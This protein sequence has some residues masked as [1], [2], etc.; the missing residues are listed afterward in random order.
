MA[1]TKKK[2]LKKTTIAKVS[3]SQ[4]NTSTNHLNP[5]FSFAK[6]KDKTNYSVNCMDAEH[7]A[8]LSKTLFKLGQSTWTIIQGSGRHGF[9]YE[10]IALNSIK[11]RQIRN[12]FPD[13]ETP[14]AFRFKGKAPM[15]GYRDDEIFHIICL[16]ARF[17]VYKH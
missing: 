14:I 2:Q 12:C 9:G 13:G 17:A 16:D 7:N 8:A 4:A 3:S 5:V 10:K 6:M 1:S 15:L 11:D